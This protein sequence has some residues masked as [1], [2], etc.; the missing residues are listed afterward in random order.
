ME[1]EEE[2]K[3]GRMVETNAVK[4]LNHPALSSPPL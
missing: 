3:G 1:E 2:E 4:R